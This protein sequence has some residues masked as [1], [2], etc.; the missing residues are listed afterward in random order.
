MCVALVLLLQ[1]APPLDL[2]AITPAQAR[3][4][5][6]KK[7]TVLVRVSKPTYTWAGRTIL[8]IGDDDTDRSIHLLGERLDVDEGD[9]ITVA[10]TLRLIRHPAQVVN[11]IR[12]REWEEI[13]VEE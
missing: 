4:L 8:G 1:A 13:R 10:G 3:R 5:D 7:V 6:G 2:E 11:G 9:E 12:V